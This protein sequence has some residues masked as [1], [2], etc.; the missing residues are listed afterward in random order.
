MT[1]I[2]RYLPHTAFG[3]TTS[4]CCISLKQVLCNFPDRLSLHPSTVW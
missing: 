3:C 2:I 4:T 1:R